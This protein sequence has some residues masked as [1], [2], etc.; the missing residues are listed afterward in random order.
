MANLVSGFGQGC[1]PERCSKVLE[2]TSPRDTQPWG[3]QPAPAVPAEML[4]P[5]NDS[6]MSGLVARSRAL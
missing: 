2:P 6:G 5:Q 1:L 4:E 3:Q